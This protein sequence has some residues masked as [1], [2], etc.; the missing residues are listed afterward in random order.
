VKE[1]LP[2]FS[3]EIGSIDFT[4]E[5]SFNLLDIRE[6]NREVVLGDLNT[7][8]VSD[9]YAATNMKLEA[10][11]TISTLLPADAYNI[12]AEDDVGNKLTVLNSTVG[13]ALKASI[14]LK[15]PVQHSQT[16]YFIVAFNL[17]WKEYVA[18]NGWNDYSFKFR[19][20]EPMNVTMSKLTVKM[21]LPEGSKFQSSDSTVQLNL[22]QDS[23]Y[24]QTPMFTVSNV[25]SSQDLNVDVEFQHVIFWSSFRPTLWMGALITI[26]G[27]VAFLWQARKAAPTTREEVTTTLTIHPEELGNYVKTYEEQTKLQRERE[28]LEAQARKGKIPRRLYRVRT[29][30]I[31]S[32]LSLLSRES[33][34][35]RERIRSA[36][37]RYSD[38]MR[39]I[40]IAQTE[41]QAVEADIERTEARYK[42]GEI[43]AVSYHKL[44]EDYYKRRDR[45]QTNT[46]G[47]LLR[48]RE[49]A[50]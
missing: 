15:A 44:L 6:V 46:E 12:I 30:T 1:P 32:R 8:F 20:F 29:R 42:R 48:L 22:L 34:A 37:P 24:S 5:T 43:S 49:E 10:T 28:N 11:S 23:I 3:H 2:A 36:G 21:S 47:V 50:G 45:A 25:S 33:A 31:E 7:L 9:F 35:L 18:L 16:A 38:M 4:A 26:V 39:Q 40:E 13:N 17:P 14:T 27:A 19:L 41:L